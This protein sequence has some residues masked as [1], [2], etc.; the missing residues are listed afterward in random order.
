M[1]I[2]LEGAS[3]IGYPIGELVRTRP[4]LTYYYFLV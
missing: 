4:T 1:L 2:K 3:L